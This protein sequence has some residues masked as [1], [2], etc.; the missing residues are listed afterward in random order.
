MRV[1]AFSRLESQFEIGGRVV[2][3]KR[4]RMDSERTSLQM[5]GRVT[6]EKQADL[7]ADLVFSGSLGDRLA[8]VL[9][10]RTIPLRIQGS[11]E[12]P[13]VVPNLSAKDLLTSGLVDRLPGWK[14]LLPGGRK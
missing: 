11:L 6:F 13:R 14:D 1:A 5:Q 9:P 10:S 4:L 2:N 8:K 3:V 12:S 7:A